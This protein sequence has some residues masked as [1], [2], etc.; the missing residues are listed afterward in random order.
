MMSAL[1]Q[2][3][4]TVISM[5]FGLK[6]GK[7]MTFAQIGERLNINRER[8]RQIEREAFRFL[9]REYSNTRNHLVTV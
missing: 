2:Q 8:V 4:Q 3:Q 6:D 1:T 9:R 7:K 5:H